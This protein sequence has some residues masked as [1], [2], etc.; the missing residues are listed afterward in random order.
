[1]RKEIFPVFILIFIVV[2]NFS[3][4]QTDLI[5]ERTDE[6]IVI[7]S[8]NIKWLGNTPHDLV[9]LANVIEHFDV[10]GILEI[11]KESTLAELIAE[12]EDKTG[13][14]WGY[15]FGFRT[16][17]PNG[18]YY[19]AYGVVWRKDR[20]E[21]GNGVISGIWDS[22]EKFRNDPY[23]VSFKRK[24][25]DF[26][27]VLIH[28]RWSNDDDGT[29]AGEVAEIAEKI[30]W[31]RGF[32]TERDIILAGDFNYS[33]NAE[34]MTNLAEYLDFTQIDPN[35]ESTFKSNY[36]GYASSYDHIYISEADTKEFIQGSSGI[37]DV[38]KVVYGNNSTANMK[39]SKQELSDHLPVWAVF[40]VTLDDDD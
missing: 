14:D 15:T 28:T 23:V 1:M 7:A 11:K 27:L 8:Y 34:P 21:L 22:N 16:N 4:S 39:N 25:F 30:H 3:Y 20:V 12:L 38:T 37:L 6:N 19:E 18:T 9:K 29:R 13:K 5:P 40:N 32:L 2:V 26:M 10:C 17:R 31:M 33:G 35:E 24:N 36:T